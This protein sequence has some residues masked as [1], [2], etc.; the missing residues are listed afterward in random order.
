M[1]S[2]FFQFW[3]CSSFQTNFEQYLYIIILLINILFL[4][5]SDD[6]S[7]SELLYDAKYKNDDIIYGNPLLTNECK[8]SLLNDGHKY[9]INLLN[10]NGFP[11]PWF[12]SRESLDATINGLTLHRRSKISHLY[13][14]NPSFIA[15]WSNTISNDYATDIKNMRADITKWYLENSKG[16]ITKIGN[17]YQNDYISLNQS[18]KSDPNLKSK[19]NNIFYYHIEK[20]GSSSIGQIL[21][22]SNFK[23]TFVSENWLSSTNCGFTFI[24]DPIERFISGYYTVNRLIYDRNYPGRYIITYPHPYKYK[25]YNITG[26]P[27]RFKQFVEDLMEYQWEFVDETPLQHI[28]SQIGILSITQA[29]IHFIGRLNKIKTHWNKLYDLCANNNF[30]KYP[31]KQHH[32]MKKYGSA[33][34]KGNEQYDKYLTMMD[35]KNWNKGDLLPVYYIIAEDYNI[36]SKIVEYYKQD[37]VC[38]GFEHDFIKFRERVYNTSG[39]N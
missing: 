22:S 25:W 13:E 1:N 28:M 32:W 20:S 6:K 21:K 3:S 10:Q 8:L 17:T 35:L 30:T 12:W 15:P 5:E 36:Y 23:Q 26:E 24:R 4:S 39:F 38:F 11:S 18:I 31:T 19:N 34:L 14:P 16:M 37:Y 29:D 27:Q 2:E 33:G 7:L 9:N